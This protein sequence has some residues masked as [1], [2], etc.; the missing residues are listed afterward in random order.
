MVIHNIE[1]GSLDTLDPDVLERVENAAENVIAKVN[2][3]ANCKKGSESIRMQ[4][5]A[6]NEY[7]DTLFGKGTADKI[8]GRK[9]NLKTALEV[10]SETTDAINAE[11]KS[12]ETEIKKIVSKYTPNRVKR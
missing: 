3:S 7:L 1:V 9:L 4:C 6:V 2:A 12:Q 10:F 5:E 8:F 11:S